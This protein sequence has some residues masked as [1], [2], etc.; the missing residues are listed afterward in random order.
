MHLEVGRDRE[1]NIFAGGVERHHKRARALD[2][3]LPHARG[4]RKRVLCVRAVS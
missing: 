1:P 3:T 2:S 4:H